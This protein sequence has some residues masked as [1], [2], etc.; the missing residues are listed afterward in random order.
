MAEYKSVLS[1]ELLKGCAERAEVYDKENSFF[2]ED[3]EQLKA[4]GY[5]TG[6]IPTEFGGGGL[7]LLQSCQEQR[8]LAYHAPATALAKSVLP[9][10]GG[11]F[12]STP[13]G[14]RPP[15]R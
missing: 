15:N 8:K 5:L 2:F 12:S 4:A 7:N 6:T 14:T 10:P 9:A 11:P 1:E 13:L 3:F